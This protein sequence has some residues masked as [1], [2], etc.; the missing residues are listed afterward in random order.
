MSDSKPKYFERGDIVKFTGFPDLFEVY[1]S[2][3]R[4]VNVVDEILLNYVKSEEKRLGT[5]Y[6]RVPSNVLE[7]ATEAEKILYG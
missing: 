6:Y 2:T 1:D 5:P 7:Y 4:P 3:Q